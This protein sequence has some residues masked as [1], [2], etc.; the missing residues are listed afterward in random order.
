MKYFVLKP[1]GNNPYSEASRRAMRAY[2]R[3]IEEENPDMCK[4]LRQWA[5]NETP[6]LID[7]TK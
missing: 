6:S 1:N 4:D 5:D 7:D 3:Y 2:A